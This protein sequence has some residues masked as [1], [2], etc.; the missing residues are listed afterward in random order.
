[1]IVGS[2][3]PNIWLAGRAGM[4]RADVMPSRK[5]CD[6]SVLPEALRH[7]AHG[8]TRERMAEA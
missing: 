2:V 8:D 4:R 5:T 3:K 7:R 6:G 1:M